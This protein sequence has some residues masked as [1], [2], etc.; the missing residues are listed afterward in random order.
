MNNCFIVQ[1]RRE[2]LFLEVCVDQRF[3]KL[4]SIMYLASIWLVLM[5]Y[6]PQ[7]SECE[8]Y[9]QKKECSTPKES[10]YHIL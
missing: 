9:V 5:C 3:E 1:N 4:L 6:L 8:G 7:I 10:R 2:K